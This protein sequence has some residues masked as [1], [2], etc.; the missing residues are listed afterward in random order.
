MRRLRNSLGAGAAALALAAAGLSSWSVALGQDKPES[1]LPPGFNDPPPPPAPPPATKRPG[2]AAGPGAVPPPSSPVA[3][4]PGTPTAPADGTD[5]PADEASADD[6]AAA[7]PV[8]AAALAAYELPSFARRS[9]T[10][11]GVVGPDQGGLGATAFQGADGRYLQQLM[12]RLRAP[13]ASRWISIGLRQALASQV[14]TPAGVNGADFAADRAWLLV[15]MGESTVAR[16]LVSA[17]DNDRYTPKLLEA[18]MQAALASADP[19][20]ICPVVDAGR[21][22]L[23]DHG[24]ILAQ[25]FCKG[26]SGEPR[27]AT[28]MIDQARRSG[29]ARGVDLLLAEKLVG[30]GSRGQRAVTIEWDSVDRLNIWR[31]GLATATAVEIPD[32]LFDTAGPQARYW[33][34]QAPIWSPSQRIPAAELAAAQGVFS[35]AAL[36]ALYSEAE[37]DDD[38]ASGIANTA[39]DLRSAYTGADAAARVAALRQ[40]WSAGA[41][42]GTGRYARLILTARAAARIPPVDA[43]DDPDQ[44]IAA[45]LSAGLDEPALRWRGVVPRGSDGWAMLSLADRNEAARVGR[46]EIEG[47][48]SGAGDGRALKARMFYA[49]L[50]GLGRLDDATRTRLATDLAVNIALENSWTR[51]L[52]RAAAQRAPGTVML[53]AAIGMQTRDWRAVSPEALFHIVAAMRRVGLVGQARMVAVEALTRL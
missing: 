22:A 29:V 11:I 44:L 4:P 1:I 39:R 15:R 49:G 16:A 34:A 41:S 48:A 36:V 2:P 19:A 24:W 30:A 46:G 12:E 42:S 52:D 9:L 13:V 32:A 50:A 6:A 43:K 23:P 47:Y 51:A 26:L 20:A 31:Y 40:L 37:G 53:L 10:R 35:N 45:M 28:P 38:T 17:V 21:A 3:S 8:D 5:L 7:I 18:A 27:T 14:D 33:Q 25:A